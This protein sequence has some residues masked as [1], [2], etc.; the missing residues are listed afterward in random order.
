[1][2]EPPTSHDSDGARPVTEPVS[3]SDDAVGK[4]GHQA[5]LEQVT[6][7][8]RR[9]GEVSAALERAEAAAAARARR[10]PAWRRV[11]Q[12]ERRLPMAI[13]ILTMIV[14]QTRVPERFTL[15]GWWVLP[16]VEAVILIA[17]VVL[18]PSRIS[19][20]ERHLRTLSLTLIGVASLANGW[21]AGYLVVGLVRGTEG[22]DAVSLLVGGGNIWVTNVL[23][24]AL[25]YWDLDRGGP[26]ARA[27]AVK[28]D[29]D[30]V[31]PQ[32]T[33]PQLASPE[34]EPNFGDYLYL[35]F[36]NATAF[37]PTDTMPFSLWSKMAM[38]LQSAISLCVGALI[39]ARAVNI[40][41]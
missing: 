2:A 12:G 18:A 40:L 29:P 36:T 32:M 20:T 37:S 8:D 5:L 39:V 15:L 6:R 19:R 25:W 10:N 30:F 28:A 38:G 1:M 26:A 4:D 13:A 7:M 33:S 16:V 9:L 27:Q 24:F 22:K 23:I 34:W 3:T 17:L 11:T 41:Q 31:F 21:A 14:L 35:A